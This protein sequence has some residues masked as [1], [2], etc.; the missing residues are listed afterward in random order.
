M[1]KY[2]RDNQEVSATQ[3]NTMLKQDIRAVETK[4]RVT[5]EDAVLADVERDGNTVVNQHK[6]EWYNTNA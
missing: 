1:K 4:H 3:W 5:I 2:Y 6:Y